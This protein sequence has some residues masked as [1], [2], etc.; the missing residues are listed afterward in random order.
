MGNGNSVNKVADDENLKAEVK[1]AAALGGGDWD[2]L[3]ERKYAVA[4]R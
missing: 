3:C 2:L 1:A 4:V